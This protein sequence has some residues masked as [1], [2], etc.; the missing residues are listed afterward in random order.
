MS[1]QFSKA[2]RAQAGGANPKVSISS[3]SEAAAHIAA[4]HE[5]VRRRMHWQLAQRSVEEAGNS[6][7]GKD[8]AE[9]AV[10]NALSTD[11]Y[12]VE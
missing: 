12:A 8:L 5:T 10:R 6:P 1:D 3:V 11:G 7:A 9:L 4:L 2:I